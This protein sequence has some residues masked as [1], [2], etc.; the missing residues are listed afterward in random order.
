MDD[1]Q[2]LTVSLVTLGDP[3]TMT[4]GYLYHRRMADLG[5]S[6]D[7][8]VD[9]VSVP[10]WRFPV[11]VLAGPAVL[12]SVIRQ[13][14]DV[15]LLDSIAAAFLGPWLWRRRLPMPLVGM[16]H[17]PPGGIDHGRARTRVQAA[18][19]R[20]AYRHAARLLVASA[21]LCEQM[22]REGIPDH[23][24]R[25]VPPGRDVAAEA[26]APQ[27]DLRAGRRAALLSVG[28]WMARKGLLD[29]LDAVAALPA[30]VVTL[31][32]VGDTEV[33][34]SYAAQVRIRLAAPDL[35]GRVVVH[36][37]R[38]PNEVAGFYRAADM[39][40]LASVREP[41]GTVYGEAMAAGLP[42]VGWDAGNLPHLARDGIEGRVVPVG[43]RA[44][45]TAALAALATDEPLRRRL[46]AAAGRRA[47]TFP[48]W[49]DTARLLFAEL[50]TVVREPGA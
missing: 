13:R 48:R 15:L 2:L 24:L 12:R 35:A 28:N 14:P 43:D 39:F 6:C 20:R 50:R 29:L 25:V 11:P 16:L 23:L 36:G 47:A 5:P 22:R 41:Y 9:F 42:V 45:L 10:S 38:S 46:G 49:E 18:F 1:A 3:R 32:L 33:E 8:R 37:R 30:D 4:G 40:A 19:D 34:P 26:V 17:Q 21:D 44:A 27:T 7:A 31:H